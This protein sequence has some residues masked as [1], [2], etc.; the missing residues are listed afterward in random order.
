[1]VD[2]FTLTGSDMTNRGDFFATMFI[3][4]AAGCLIFYFMLGYTTNLVAQV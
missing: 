1:M 3:V 4:M 2:V